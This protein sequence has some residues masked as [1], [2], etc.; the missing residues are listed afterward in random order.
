M[1]VSLI[2]CTTVR[3]LDERLKGL[4]EGIEIIV[5]TH[6]EGLH[7]HGSWYYAHLY[8]PLNASLNYVGEG[9][10]HPNSI[11]SKSECNLIMQSI[12]VISNLYF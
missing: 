1:C 10:S 6:L 2:H 8:H 4:V 7:L 12:P 5:L 3:S 11:H 9:S